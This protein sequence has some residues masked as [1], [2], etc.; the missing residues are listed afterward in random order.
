MRKV[1]SAVTAVSASHRLVTHGWLL[2][3]VT[4]AFPG[5]HL[6]DET[7]VIVNQ[8]AQQL[9]LVLDWEYDQA[10]A[11]V[12][13]Y[14]EGELVIVTSTQRFSLPLFSEGSQQLVIEPKNETTLMVKRR[15][16]GEG[17]DNA[18]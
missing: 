16:V 3:D 11:N 18:T 2:I 10:L 15:I 13:S 6:P 5:Y 12:M 9:D 17:H 7:L 14:Y 4:E 8:S 1:T